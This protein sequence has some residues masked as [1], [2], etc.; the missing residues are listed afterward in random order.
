MWHSKPN[1]K[2]TFLNRASKI[3]RNPTRAKI[4]RRNQTFP[5]T[6]RHI[7]RPHPRFQNAPPVARRQNRKTAGTGACS[8][9]RLLLSALPSPP[10]NIAHRE[11]NPRTPATTAPPRI[12]RKPNRTVADGGR[13]SSS[14]TSPERASRR[15]QAI[16][17]PADN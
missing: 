14:S 10:E 12:F 11:K 8:D 17:K 7:P 3:F 5:G 15:V 16:R 4:S 6:S 13:A 1:E 2:K 9:L